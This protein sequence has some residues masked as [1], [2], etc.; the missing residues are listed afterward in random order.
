MSKLMTNDLKGH[1]GHVVESENVDVTRR[2]YLPSMSTTI[3]P[4]A[5]CKHISAALTNTDGD[6]LLTI[7]ENMP[8]KNIPSGFIWY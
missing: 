1:F 2:I 3:F 4:L 6:Q 5:D 7:C 8:T